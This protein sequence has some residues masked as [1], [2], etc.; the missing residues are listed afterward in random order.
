M[1]REDY[2]EENEDLQ[3]TY[4]WHNCKQI[5]HQTTQR[6]TLLEIID[7]PVWG[8]SCFMNG[9]V[10]SCEADERVYHRALVKPTLK[11]LGFDDLRIAVFGGGEGATAREVFQNRNVVH[12][13]MFDWD[14]EVVT[15]FRTQFRQWGKAAWED[16]R[17]HLHFEDAFQVVKRPPAEL[18][19]AVI[20]D[21]FDIDKESLSQSLEFL[22]HVCKWTKRNIGMYVTTQAPF[23]K[24]NHTHIRKLRTV[25]RNGGFK[26][27]LSSIYV[28]SFHGYAV[29]L[30]GVA[31]DNE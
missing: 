1:N 6:G 10:Q 8:L 24:P 28:P 22:E 16:P 11:G 7:R 19:D 25:L 9:I 14:E 30:V 26:T 31:S 4:T 20:I 5:F 2:K 17:L 13:D 21:M 18:Y 15:T 27:H 29:F 3:A 12:L 23:L